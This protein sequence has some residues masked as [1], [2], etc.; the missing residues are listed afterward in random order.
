MLDEDLLALG[1]ETRSRK[2]PAKPR[3][4]TA[5]F[6]RALVT[7]AVR[8]AGAHQILRGGPGVVGLLLDHL[9]DAAA[10]T[11]AAMA[12]LRD[13]AKDSPIADWRTF[14]WAP[15]ATR[16]LATTWDDHLAD[17]D[18]DVSRVIAFA[19]APDGLSTSFLACADGVAAIGRPG[20][21]LL[22]VGFK[23]FGA[24]AP[25][26][27]PDAPALSTVPLGAYGSILRRGGSPGAAAK[28][29]R[30]ADACAA[31]SK[32]RS[33]EA[34]DGGPTL[35]DLHGLGEASVWGRQLAVDLAEY[36][37]GRLAWRD[38][39]R[40]IL[41]S[42]P[43]GTGKTTFARALGRSCG[44]PVFVHSLAR[45]QAAGYLNDLLRSMRSAFAEAQA[46]APSILFVD[47]VDSFGDRAKLEGKN[48]QYS[49]EVIAGFLECL[50][51]ADRRTGVVV[52]GATN[53]PDNIDAAIKRAGRLD[54]HV[55]IPLPDAEARAGILR[56]HLGAD[57]P[58]C[59]LDAVAAS[60]Q[61]MSGA[62]LE[63]AVRNARRIARTARRPMTPD[64]LRRG[65]PDGIELSAETFRRACVHEAGHLVV[66]TWL[67][68]ETVSIPVLARV[69]RTVVGNEGGTTNFRRD[70]AVARTRE[71]YLAEITVYLAGLA[72]ERVVFGSNAH[73]GGGLRGSD[74][75]RA[76]CLA[77]A[78]EVSLGLGDR[79]AFLDEFN[80]DGLPLHLQRDPR[81]RET[82]ENTLAACMDR[83]TKLLRRRREGFNEIARIIADEGE[84]TLADACKALGSGP[85]RKRRPKR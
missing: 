11:T 72:A 48:R 63:K 37:A 70:E 18:R 76:T 34:A 24:R 53:D 21:D 6:A 25:V 8:A 45:W 68:R 51:G 30:L 7:R 43:P 39:D 5:F 38:V 74:L 42:G 46:A 12:L 49:V 10:F 19:E 13:T 27:L 4:A 82:V 14:N 36:K 60:L 50:D 78:I 41:L 35:D 65:L 28:I 56:H 62:D 59:D 17:G 79:L 64:D 40:G 3:D 47:E 71:S 29:A 80:S 67:A 20:P 23:V 22:R 73:G 31:A 83:A 75:H 44:V 81:L 2:R 84:A 33:N 55:A 9:E 1:G 32:G 52:V 69:S 57:V 54:R 66:G 85:I 15:T 77:V 16:R 26:S 58:G 61:G